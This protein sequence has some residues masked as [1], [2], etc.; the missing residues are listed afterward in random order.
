MGE[1]KK[2]KEK[3]VAERTK[4]VWVDTLFIIHQ[5]RGSMKKWFG[6]EVPVYMNIGGRGEIATFRE[7]RDGG[8]M[9]R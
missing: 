9:K 8:K 1:E 3:V 5:I 2:K 6:T 7:V 4:L